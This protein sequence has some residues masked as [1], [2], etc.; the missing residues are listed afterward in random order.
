MLLLAETLLGFC[1]QQLEHKWN[2]APLLL[3]CSLPLLLLLLQ[4][5]FW[6]QMLML[7]VSC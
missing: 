5:H 3:G 2:Y 6:Q 4:R 7:A 1:V